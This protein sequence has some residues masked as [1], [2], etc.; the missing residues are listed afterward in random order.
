[1]TFRTGPNTSS[2]AIVISLFVQAKITVDYSDVPDV[3]DWAEKA[4]D[5][6][7]KWYPIISETLSSKEFT[8]QPTPAVAP[9]S[10][11]RISPVTKEADSR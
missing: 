2:R 9:P 8:R 4:R 11:W 5:L 3:K 10:T 6:C 1:M 7:E